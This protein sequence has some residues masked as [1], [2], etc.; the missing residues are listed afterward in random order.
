MHSCAIH[1]HKQS[2]EAMLLQQCREV[3]RVILSITPWL[4]TS[5]GQSLI[6]C[7]TDPL[8]APSSSKD[9]NAFLTVYLRF[10]WQHRNLSRPSDLQPELTPLTTTIFL[11]PVSSSQS[12]ILV[13]VLSFSTASSNLLHQP[14][15]APPPFTTWSRSHY[16]RYTEPI[17]EKRRFRLPTTQQPQ[18]VVLGY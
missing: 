4:S 1:V 6:R 15:L 8:V 2:V 9:L 10:L 12:I 11:L 17:A 7:N 18:H 5:M 16:N 3:T 14:S 13:C